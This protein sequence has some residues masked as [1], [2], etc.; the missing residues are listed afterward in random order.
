[1]AVAGKGPGGVPAAPDPV[2]VVG[3]AC[4]LP[5]APDPAAFWRLLRSGR[6]AIGPVPA[7]RWSDPDTAAR[8]GFLDEVDRFDAGFFGISP[9]EAAAMDPQQRLVLELGWEGLEDAGI[10]PADLAGSR[11]GV[12]VGAIWDDYATLQY[13]QGTAAITPHTVTGLHRSIIANRLS[14]TL[15][16][17]GPSLAVDAGQ[18]SSLVAVHLACGSLRSGDCDLALAGGVNLNLAPE[19]TVGAARFGALSPDGRCYTFDERANGY[20]RGEGAGLVVLKRLSRAVADGDEIYC[21]IRGSAVNNDGGGDSLT[22]PSRAGQE[23]VLRRAY[24]HAGI[25]PRTVQYVELHGTGT[26]RGDPVEAAALGTVL[27]AGRAPREPLAVGSVKTNVGHLEGAAG[28]TGLIKTALAVRHRELPASLHFERPHPDIPLDEL[29]LRVQTGLSR[30]PRDGE[31]L[32]AGVSSFG[33]GGTNCH[34]V[35]S[36]PDPRPSEVDSA[37][38]RP[39]LVGWVV[40]ARTAAALRGQAQRLREDLSGDPAEVAYALATTRTS[41]PHRAVVLAGDADG[42]RRGLTALVEGEPSSDVVSGTVVAGGLAFLFA[43]QGSQRLGMGRELYEQHPVFAA[44]L[45]AVCARLDPAVRE[46]LFAEPTPENAARLDQTAFTQTALFAVEVA[47]YRLVESW[48]VVPDHLLG[49]SVGELAA[50]H[51]AGALSLDDACTLVSA[52]GRLMQALP[53]GGAMVA[54]QA[55]EDEVAATLAGS[56]V[57]IAA[58]NGPTSTVVSGD[59]DAVDAVAAQWASRGRKTRR[60]RVS[61]AFHSARM[62]AMAADFRAVAAGLTV[63]AP[64]IPVISNVTGEPLTAGEIRSPDYWVRHARRAVR[65]ADG[66]RWLRGQGVVTFLELG[67]DG[68]LS[69]LARECVAGDGGLPAAFVPT[70]RRDRPE[71]RSLLTALA[72]LHVRGAAPAR[73]GLCGPGPARRVALPTYAFQR[74]RHWLDTVATGPSPAVAPPAVASPAV[75]APASEADGGV[76]DRWRGRLAGL[77]EADQLAAV[78]DRVRREI[79][80]V[81][82]HDADDEIDSSWPFKDLGFDSLTAVELRDRLAA[83]GGVDLSTTVLFDYPTPAA[84]AVRLRALLLGLADT[85]VEPAPEMAPGEPIAIVGMACRYPGGVRSP[86]D[87]W[88]IVSDGVDAI[89]PFPEDRGWDLDALYDPDPARH[90]TSYAREGGFLPDAAEFDPGLFGISPREALAMDPQQRLLLETAWEA[91]ERAGI[92][93]VSL[94][95]SRTGV[96]AGATAQDYG[97][98]LH[99]A[100]EGAEGYTLTGNA[101]SVISGRVAYALGLE[102][103]AITVDTACSASLVALHLAVQALRQGECGL[104]LAGGVT[105]MPTPGMFVEFSRQRGLAPDGRCKPFAAAADGTGWSEG[106]GVLVLERLSEARRN[107]H[108]VLAVVRGSAV[109]QDG[110][111]NGLTAPNGPSQQR[112]IRAALAGA[113]LRPS[114]VDA[115]EAHGTGTTLGDPIEA[116][117]LIETYGRDRAEDRPLWLG[118]V[119][120]NIGHTQAAAGVAGVIKMVLAL[121]HRR[122]PRTLHVDSPSPHIDWSSGAVSLLTEPVDWVAPDRPRRAAVSSFGI[123][124]TNAHVIVEESSGEPSAITVPGEPVLSSGAVPWVLSARSAAAV[125]AQAGRLAVVDAAVA[126]VGWALVDQRSVFEHRAVVWGAS[127]SSLLAGLGAVASGQGA[128]NAATGSVASGAGPVFVFPGQGSQWLGMGRELLDASPVF[129]A[130]LAECAAALSSY[131][132][133]SVRDVLTGADDAWLGRVD[134]VQPV[135][136]AVHVSLAAV[137]ESL[138]V[139]P[140]AVVGHSQGEI[141]AAVVAGAL[142]LEDGARVVALRSRAIRAI[143]GRGGMLS[144]AAGRE[145]VSEW[146]SRW[147]G[148]T[149]AV[150]NGPGA[151]VVSG[152]PLALDELASFVEAQGVRARRVPVD[153]A[154]H[155]VDVEEIRERIESDLAGITP[156]SSRLPLYSTVTGELLDTA[157]MDG[158]YWFTNLRQTVRFADAVTAVHVAGLR[159]WVEVSAH[160]VLT[161]AVEETVDAAVVTGTLRRDEGGADRLIAS[162]AALWVAGGTVDWATVFAGRSVERVDLPTYP[163]ERQR[164]WLRPAPAGGDMAAAGL[165]DADH[166]LLGAAVSVADG[167]VL[168]TGRLSAGTVPWLADHQV[169]GTVLFP[170]TGF[171]ELA[172]RAGDEVGCPYVRELTLQAPLVLPESGAVQVQV[173]VDRRAG[174]PGPLA[175]G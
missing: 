59:A 151:T 1:M 159:H 91:V 161:M 124:G 102:G 100:P 37:P 99:E 141:A 140:A 109:N 64:A 28:I 174:G 173:S 172:I 111:S 88:R 142:S 103:P 56:G 11:A 55:G 60:L 17:R 74:K 147:P 51:V 68:V 87:L 164:Y 18:S 152:A 137:W 29:G 146:L 23:D 134:V 104:A 115:V 82:G 108:R 48:G 49:H 127:R 135:L 14:H 156:T 76:A 166:P 112:V 117:A 73:P 42:F 66:V 125:A 131:V 170:G 32:V 9:R 86:E 153:Y 85:P 2:A 50:A 26:R 8:G 58:V 80:A 24:D 15:G 157:G 83:A 3:L 160:P 47:L 22:V 121:R 35:V 120:S 106:V 169:A 148:L 39:D 116:Q 143:A 67:P 79:A 138:G 162:A 27:G 129:A 101:S 93:P 92:A 154:S 133:W 95:G 46:L 139:R 89:T 71:G 119:K 158:T 81:L 12:F 33:M 69:A 54:L 90:G 77:S 149:V 113:R 34:V 165:S 61:H 36:E 126:D 63:R 41:F 105:V 30:W 20:V 21:V 110:A 163:F 167:G 53:A 44:A 128:G 136:W 6:D 98:R 97:A 70:L 45:D 78:L 4:R 72:G 31:R 118:S 122:L 62:D 5:A 19:S 25:D 132:D 150:V 84:L 94:R 65:F 114:D 96:F 52:R 144:L 175:T 130:R 155:G 145:Q 168:L 171:V 7:G 123:S 75:A 43:G 16:L 13:R 38:T 57:D 10:V 107:G 40:S